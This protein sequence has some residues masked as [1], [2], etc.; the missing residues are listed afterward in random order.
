METKTKQNGKA[1]N[2]EIKDIISGNGVSNVTAE[3]NGKVINGDVKTEVQTEK[4]TEKVVEQ[5]KVVEVL[6]MSIDEK[7]SKIEDLKIIIDKREKLID[8][9]K[10][11]NS[12]VLGS[13]HSNESVTLTDGQGHTFT[14]TNTEVLSSV[15]DVIRNII[16]D[17]IKDSENL[18]SF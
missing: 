17:K 1:T 2:T 7:I 15:I 5:Q 16:D 11:L 4:T 14:A 13:H 9:R 6:K 10:K 8:S 18:I 12:F 3:K